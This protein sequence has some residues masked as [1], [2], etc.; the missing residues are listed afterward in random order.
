MELLPRNPSS[1]YVLV[2]HF[3]TLLLDFSEISGLTIGSRSSS[4]EFGINS[5]ASSSLANKSTIEFCYK[6]NC[7]FM[8]KAIPSLSES[9]LSIIRFL[10]FTGLSLLPFLGLFFLLVSLLF[11]DDW[12]EVSTCALFELLFSLSTGTLFVG[13]IFLLAFS[14]AVANNPLIPGPFFVFCKFIILLHYCNYQRTWCTRLFL[15]FCLGYM[16]NWMVV[17]SIYRINWNQT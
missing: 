4:S 17:V 15:R 13:S 10:L 3:L 8:M 1:S 12:V 11:S 16:K 14:E 6:I 9:C 5:S 7:L 2:T